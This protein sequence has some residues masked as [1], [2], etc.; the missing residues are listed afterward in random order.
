MT[1]VPASTPFPVSVPRYPASLGAR[2][3]APRAPGE[4]GEPRGSAPKE[5]GG[6]VAPFSGAAEDRHF[7]AVSRPRP[8]PSLLAGSIPGMDASRLTFPRSPG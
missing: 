2:L 8:P 7:G 6:V 5:Q 4:V 1:L 3:E